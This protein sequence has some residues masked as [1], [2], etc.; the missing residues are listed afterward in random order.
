MQVLVEDEDAV[1][2]IERKQKIKILQNHAN[3]IKREKI[4][5]D[6]LTKKIIPIKELLV[7]MRRNNI[8]GY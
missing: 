8:L 4:I 3:Y 5:N 2:Y 1:N 6:E 7:R